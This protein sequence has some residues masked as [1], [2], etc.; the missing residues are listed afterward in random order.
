M[1]TLK[2]PCGCNFCAICDGQGVIEG[3]VNLKTMQAETIE[4]PACEGK[5]NFAKCYQHMGVFLDDEDR[6]RYES[7][8]RRS[9]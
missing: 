2:R 5:D 4:C 1:K 7:Y 8:Q 6:K 9:A 3:D